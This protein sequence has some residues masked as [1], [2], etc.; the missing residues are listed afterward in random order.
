[1]V[2]TGTGATLAQPVSTKAH[3]HPPPIPSRRSMV[4]FFFIFSLTYK[5]LLIM[6]R[7]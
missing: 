7:I 1:V 6:I 3:S 5:K 4:L 2:T